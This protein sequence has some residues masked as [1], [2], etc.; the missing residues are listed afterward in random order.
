MPFFLNFQFL[1]LPFSLVI[2][3]FFLCLHHDLSQQWEKTWK[4]NCLNPEPRS[5]LQKWSYYA[6]ILSSNSKLK[7]QRH[8]QSKWGK[9]RSRSPIK[10]DVKKMSNWLTG[11]LS[12]PNQKTQPS[13]GFL[14][15]SLRQSRL[16]SSAQY[17]SLTLIQS[18]SIILSS[19][20]DG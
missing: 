1:L 9:H 18:H 6:S 4:T 8:G 14:D 11:F 10:Q 16:Q 5:K 19:A 13:P 3:P 12:I 17:Y 2:I 7:K 15:G 20:K